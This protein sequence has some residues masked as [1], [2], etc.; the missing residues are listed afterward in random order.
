MNF[1][2]KKINSEEYEKLSK[3][4]IELSNEIG[5]LSSKIKLVQSDN[6]NLRGQFNRKLLGFKK[7]E[8]PQ[9]NTEESQGINNPVILPDNGHNFKSFR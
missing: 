8:T 9:E 3:K 1:W 4:L 5:E 2:N 6:A 7:E